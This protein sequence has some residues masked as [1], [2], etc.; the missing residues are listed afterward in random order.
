MSFCMYLFISFVLSFCIYVVRYFF[1][2][3]VGLR[4][5]YFRYFFSFVS[6]FM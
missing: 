5:L 1:S 6:L 3:L 4:L 2:S